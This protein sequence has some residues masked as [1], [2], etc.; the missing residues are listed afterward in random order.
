LATYRSAIKQFVHF[1]QNSCTKLE[2]ITMP[3]RPC[4]ICSD[5]I[6]LRLAAEMIASGASDQAVADRIGGISR[7]AV[8]RHRQNHVERP[9]KAVVAAANKAKD[10]RDE[11]EQIVAAAESG[12]TAAA[13]LALNQIAA[14]LA[15]KR[16]Q[17]LQ[18]IAPSMSRVA[19][20]WNPES[21]TGVL[22]WQEI[23]GPARQLGIELHSLEVRPGGDFDAA[24]A[25]VIEA[26]DH[27]VMVLPSGPVFMVNQQRI[28]DFAAKHRLPLMDLPESV[29]AGGLLAYGP[30]RADLFRRAATYV[31]KILKG[32]KPSDLP[33]QQPTKF[34]LVINLQTAKTLGL[35]VPPMLLARADEVIE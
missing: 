18:E 22:A 28:A 9:A 15:T 16:L 26:N 2:G 32:A 6:K 27:A 31:D 25:S 1:V 4:Q 13:F 7:M 5:A 33:V 3:G 24:F 11:R 20:L 21:G 23:Q 29:R 34:E 30:D 12:D 10:V 8:A 19:V 35:T 17:L 14:D